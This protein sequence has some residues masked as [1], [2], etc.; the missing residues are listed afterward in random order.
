MLYIDQPVQVGLSYD[1]PT[2]ITVDRSIRDDEMMQ[3]SVADFT[4][5]IP[6]QNNTFYVGTYAT[7]QPLSV[8]NSTNHSA[9]A[10][11]HF[12]QTW[13]EEFPH[14]KPADEKISIWTE[15][16]GGH[17]GP[18]FARFF[19]QQ[20]DLITDGTINGPGAH[21]IHL[22]ML[23]LV[24][25]CVDDMIEAPAYADMAYNNTYGIEAINSSA[26]ELSMSHWTKPGGVKD[27]IL[28]CRELAGRFDPDDY[29]DNPEVNE[30]CSAANGAI[31]MS[32]NVPYTNFSD[33][34]WFDIGHPARDPFPP[35]YYRGYLNRPYVQSAIGAVVNHSDVSVTVANAFQRTADKPRGGYLEDIAYVLD[36]GMKVALMYGDRDYACNW[37]GGERV[38]LAIP[39][40]DA[41]RFAQAGYEPIVVN[42]SYMGGQVRQSGNLSFSR[43]Y[44]AGHM[45]PAYQPETA[46]RIFMRAMFGRDVATGEKVV[47]DGFSTEGPADTWHIRNEIPET[48][49]PEC[50]ILSPGGCSEAQWEA[51]KNG[52]AVIKNY[53]FQ[54][55]GEDTTVRG[56]D[57]DD[58]GRPGAFDWRIRMG[59]SDQ[60]PIGRRI[61]PVL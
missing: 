18:A 45:V 22:D 60:V 20:N 57:D 6:E 21:Y 10:L 54:T 40:R 8:T 13:F 44:Q 47:T 17:Y 52:T 41:Q 11:W 16:Y 61:R 32:M 4:D 49:A 9:I 1:V 53:I 35:P 59:V 31:A 37:I 48:P 43:V 2:N 23:G 15:S 25:A 33:H 19:S 5:G 7:Q 38:S 51:V 3:V 14:Y 34:G 36:R 46:Y 24:N 26:Y 27:L 55:F 12:A 42:S 29:G 39:Y 30:A 56:D 58:D 28:H 50:Y